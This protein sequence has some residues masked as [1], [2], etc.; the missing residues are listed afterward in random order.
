MFGRMCC[1][2]SEVRF[3]HV[4]STLLVANPSMRTEYIMKV[5]TLQSLYGYGTSLDFGDTLTNIAVERY[6]NSATMGK[7][8]KIISNQMVQP[9]YIYSI[10][11]IGL[12]GLFVS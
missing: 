2:S 6:N 8:N 10:K 5:Q 11:N 9:I 4:Q 7:L 12:Y 1:S 3:S